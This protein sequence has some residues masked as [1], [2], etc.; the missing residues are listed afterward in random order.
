MS[1]PL[2]FCLPIPWVPI[3]SPSPDLLYFPVR[4][5]NTQHW[6]TRRQHLTSHNS[7]IT[8]TIGNCRAEAQIG[9]GVSAPQVM[10]NAQYHK[11]CSL[12]RHQHTRRLETEWYGPGHSGPVI[13]QR[14]GTDQMPLW[15]ASHTE[16]EGWIR[17]VSPTRYG[18][19]EDSYW[20]Q[21]SVC[22]WPINTSQKPIEFH[23]SE[24]FCGLALVDRANSPSKSEFWGIFLRPYKNF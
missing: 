20:A 15:V 2:R 24:C 7:T 13:A 19:R 17:T 22:W 23:R 6:N 18:E 4:L 12:A 9:L 5:I 11:V 21:P 3:T 14:I 1:S 8:D 16:I 10:R